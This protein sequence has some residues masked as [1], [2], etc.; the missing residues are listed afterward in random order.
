V[1]PQFIEIS[2]PQWVCCQRTDCALG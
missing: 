2:N 1:H